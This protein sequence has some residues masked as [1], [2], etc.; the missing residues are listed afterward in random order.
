VLAAACRRAAGARG[1]S[2]FRAHRRESSPAVNSSGAMR[3]RSWPSTLVLADEPTANLDSETGSQI[4]DLM[5]ECNRNE[6]TTFVFSSHD[7][8]SS[9][10]PR[11]SSSWPTGGSTASAA[12]QTAGVSRY[13]RRRRRVTGP[14]AALDSSSCC[15]ACD[16]QHLEPPAE[17]RH[18]R[19]HAAVDTLM[20]VL[21]LSIMH[22]IDRAMEDNVRLA[23]TGDLQVYSS[24]ALEPSTCWVD[25]M[26]AGRRRAS[27]LR[28]R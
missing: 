13:P 6:S 26:V 25:P 22:S 4:V 24:T 23:L 16:T 14:M 15:C 8:P 7:P 18:H 27:Q 21:G 10:R 17:E 12:V 1:L 2:D 19:R 5:L 20:L 11:V 28:R 3:G 9:P